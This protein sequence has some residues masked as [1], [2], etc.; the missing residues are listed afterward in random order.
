MIS[1]RDCDFILQI[2][3]ASPHSGSCGAVPGRSSDNKVSEESQAIYN[4][5]VQEVT[6]LLRSSAVHTI[7][8]ECG[9]VDTPNSSEP[10]AE[11]AMKGKPTVEVSLN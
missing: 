11:Q 9:K 7:V 10:R 2:R 3:L 6:V 5:A 1:C 4:A 8:A